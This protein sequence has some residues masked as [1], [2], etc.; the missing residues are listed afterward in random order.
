[1]TATLPPE[2]FAWLNRL[3]QMYFPPDRNHID[4]HVTLFHAIPPSGEDELR[5]LLADLAAGSGPLA[6]E[7]A[8]VISL[9]R[10]TAFGIVSPQL[11]DLRALIAD[12]FAGMLTAQDMHR[13]RL[14][15]TVQNKVTPEAARALKQ[16]LEHDFIARP[17]VFAGLEAH[18]YLGGPWRLAG[19]W[20]FRR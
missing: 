9:G 15:V 20:R 3:R 13:P 1:M 10:G 11:L 4:A 16:E 17:F 7:L 12:R 6:A 14:H 2:I 8:S 5:H 19:Q 18:Y